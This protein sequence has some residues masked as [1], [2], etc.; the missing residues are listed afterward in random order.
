VRGVRLGRSFAPCAVGRVG[1]LLRGLRVV[2]LVC[3]VAAFGRV[4][5]GLCVGACGAFVRVL[6]FVRCAAFLGVL[7]LLGG[8]LRGLLV[9][10]VSLLS[11]F[12]RCRLRVGSLCGVC[13]FVGLLR[14]LAGLLALLVGFLGGFGVV[15]VGLRG[16]VAV[17]CACGACPVLVLVAVGLLGL[18]GLSC[19]FLCRFGGCVGLRV[20][21]ALCGVLRLL[22][23]FRCAVGFLAA[24]AAAAS[25]RACAVCVLR[26]LA[27]VVCGLAGV[28][29]AVRGGPPSRFPVAPC[30]RLLLFSLFSCSVSLSFRS[31]FC[32]P[33]GRCPSC[34]SVLSVRCPFF[35]VLRVLF[36]VSVRCVP[37]APASRRCFASWGRCGGALRGRGTRDTALMVEY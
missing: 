6:A 37:C 32:C 20:A 4:V 31:V 18:P 7:G 33:S 11:R 12:L 23:V 29:V 22:C 30:L 3:P 26:G 1:V 9:V 17:A 24:L 10:F 19:G 14:G 28:G 8:R 5:P 21:C 13:R 36:F 2:P 16:R 34:P 27:G 35:C 15:G 25:V